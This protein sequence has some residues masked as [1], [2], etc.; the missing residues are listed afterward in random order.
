[1]NR[2]NIAQVVIGLTVGALLFAIFTYGR[3]FVHSKGLDAE[4]AGDAAR[5]RELWKIS[6]AL[7]YVQSKTTLGTLYLIGRGGPQNPDGAGR[8][9]L[10][11]AEAG[12]VD[13]Q[14]IYGMAV[15]SG[16]GLPR[17]LERGRYWLEKAASQG[18][19][20]AREFLNMFRSQEK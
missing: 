12:D 3:I 10:S 18:D 16:E 19:R 13:A 9:L 7:G 5:A 14:S 17:D 2:N 6:A 11:A 8:L 4:S 1:M 15:Y 20:P